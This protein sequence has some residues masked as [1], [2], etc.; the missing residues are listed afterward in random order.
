M[1]ETRKAATTLQDISFT[2]AATGRIT[3]VSHAGRPND[4]WSYAYDDLDRL[5]TATNT[6]DPSL[7]QTFA[8]ACPGLDPGTPPT[9]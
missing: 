6:G 3:A 5:V 8:A 2:R 4:S 7:S 9:T 1:I